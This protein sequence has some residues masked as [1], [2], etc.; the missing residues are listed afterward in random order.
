M[1]TGSVLGLPPLALATG[2]VS[3]MEVLGS[4]RDPVA[5]RLARKSEQQCKR[6]QADCES[7]ELKVVA[8]ADHFQNM[9]CTAVL[10]L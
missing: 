6:R 9:V 7:T 8:S 4:S 2:C 10:A 5:E 1:A 3:T